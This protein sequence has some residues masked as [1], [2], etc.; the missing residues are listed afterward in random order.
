MLFTEVLVATNLWWL[1]RKD[2]GAH[3]FIVR[4]IPF[5]FEVLESLYIQTRNLPLSPG[6]GATNKDVVNS[7]VITF[8]MF[9][10]PSR[11]C[12]RHMKKLDHK[13]LK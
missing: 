2:M 5:L 3:H 4:L 6:I 9:V 12:F 8:S 1:E 10:P 13:Q 11:T 7:Y